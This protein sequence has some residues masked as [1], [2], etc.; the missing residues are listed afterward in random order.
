MTHDRPHQA[1][2]PEQARDELGVMVGVGTI[3]KR[4]ADAVLEAAGSAP[5]ETR[6]GYPAGL[7]EREIEV[8][9]L[10]AQG[11]TNREIGEALVITEKTAGHHVEHIYAKADV[12]ARRSGPLRH[13]ARPG[14]VAQH[15]ESRRR[16][17]K[18]GRSPD[19]GATEG[20]WRRDRMTGRE[21]GVSMPETEA[22]GVRLYYEI[23]GTASPSCWSMDRG[24]MQ[25][26]G[27]SWCPAW[28]SRSVSLSTTAAA[29]R[30]EDR[31]AGQRR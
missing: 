28:R 19:A 8:L 12:S 29:S 23:H 24:W 6:Q 11:K 17:P 1:L 10:L 13:A 5:T 4:A 21:E 27:A 25:R 16:V 22:N 7:T 14:R 20:A 31:C 15:R 18:M 3:E 2:G 26:A 9:R 30:S